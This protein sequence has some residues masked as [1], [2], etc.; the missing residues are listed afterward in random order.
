MPVPAGAVR[1]PNGRVPGASA[2]GFQ[3]DIESA[4]RSI[5]MD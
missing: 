3:Q 5:I 2:E 4:A 1:R